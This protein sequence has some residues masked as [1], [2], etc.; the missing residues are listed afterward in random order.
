MV[1]F[2]I[3]KRSVSLEGD[4]F[5]IDQAAIALSVSCDFIARML[6]MGI[7]LYKG[8]MENPLIGQDEIDRLEEVRRIHDDLGINWP[9][10]SLIVDLLHENAKLI[11]ELA[12]MRKQL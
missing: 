3:E 5:S 2:W 4:Y 10:A 9:G 11:R 12:I 1:N 6:E 8:T 7:I